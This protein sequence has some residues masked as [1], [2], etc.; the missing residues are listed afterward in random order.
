MGHKCTDGFLLAPSTA[1]VKS[2]N[3]WKAARDWR[4]KSQKQAALWQIGV[5]KL[6]STDYLWASHCPQ[7]MRRPGGSQGA[8]R[9]AKKGHGFLTEVRRDVTTDGLAKGKTDMQKALSQFSTLKTKAANVSAT[10]IQSPATQQQL[11]KYT[12]CNK[13]AEFREISPCSLVDTFRRDLLA[14]SSG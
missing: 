14:P 11:S 2:S 4:R 1:L 6:L 9:Y 5:C 3:C 13:F 8:G 10:F 7:E 12:A